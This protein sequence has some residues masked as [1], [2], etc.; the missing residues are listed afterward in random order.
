MLVFIIYYLIINLNEEWF[1]VFDWLFKWCYK[2]ISLFL[3]KISG[4]VKVFSEKDGHND[5]NQNN[6]LIPF[7]VDDD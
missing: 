3:P 5:K 6:K 1:Q 7:R 2:T 4:Y